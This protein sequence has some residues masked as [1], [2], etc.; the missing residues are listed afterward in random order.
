MPSRGC[1]EMYESVLLVTVTREATTDISLVRVWDAVHGIFLYNQ[2]L[3]RPQC[4]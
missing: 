4:Q 2:K 1:L 3:S